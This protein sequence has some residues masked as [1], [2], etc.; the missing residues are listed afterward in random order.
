MGAEWR[1]W[2]KNANA[3]VMAT[4]MR[5]YLINLKRRPDRLAAMQQQAAGL[6]LE[7]VASSVRKA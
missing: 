3:P 5:T 7:R 6:T 1:K 4:G 2:G